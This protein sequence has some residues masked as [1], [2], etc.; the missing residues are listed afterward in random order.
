M[1]ANKGHFLYLTDTVWGKLKERAFTE[2]QTA[3]KLIAYLLRQALE[4]PDLIPALPRYQGRIAREDLE[5]RAR[6]NV[7]GIPDDIWERSEQAVKASEQSISGRVEYLLHNY[8][9]LNDAIEEDEE[10]LEEPPGGH[11]LSTGKTTYNL[12][13]DPLEIDLT[14]KKPPANRPR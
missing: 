14:Q 1:P 11:L 8:L 6:R 2:K 10:A 13:P 5:K 12:G 7:R 3:G 9:G 4:N